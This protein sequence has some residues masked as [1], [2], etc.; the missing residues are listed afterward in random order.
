[1]MTMPWLLGVVGPALLAA[2]FAQ[3]AVPVEFT[4]VERGGQS[5]IERPREA[6]VRTA[7]EWTALWTEHA[8]DRERPPV[9]FTTSM[10]VAVFLGS[11]PTGGY[12]VELTSVERNS[13]GTVVTYRENR[14]AKDM[15]TTQVITMPFVI[16]SLP[17]SD[18][19]VRFKHAG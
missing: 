12:S 14:P 2:A 10:I 8:T 15:M 19:P 3:P 16:A 6:V 18:G 5:N 17:K 11:R 9:D 1:M 7:A 4:V 13:E